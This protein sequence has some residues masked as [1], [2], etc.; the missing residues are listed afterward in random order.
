MQNC[1]YCST[2]MEDYATV[3]PGC[4]A[5]KILTSPEVSFRWRRA[6][7]GIIL[8]EGILVPV[9]IYKFE[10]KTIWVIALF[11]LLGFIFG[12]FFGSGKEAKYGWRR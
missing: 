10:I 4:G 11:I 5:E 3:C 1:P 8:S 6:I 9:L 2:S 7:I 12:L